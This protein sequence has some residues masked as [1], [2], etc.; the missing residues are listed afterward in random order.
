MLRAGG[1]VESTGH[2]EALVDSLGFL[3]AFPTI[4]AMPLKVPKLKH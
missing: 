1:R 2:F 4:P 3:Q